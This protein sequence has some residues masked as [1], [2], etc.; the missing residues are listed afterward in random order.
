MTHLENVFLNIVFSKVYFSILSAIYSSVYIIYKSTE[1]SFLV[2]QHEFLG[3]ES[4][5][6]LK[7]QKIMFC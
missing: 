5:I 3:Q 6:Q 7:S 1:E 4:I 2:L